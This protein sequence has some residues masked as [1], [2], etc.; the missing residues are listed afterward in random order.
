MDDQNP[1]LITRSRIDSMFYGKNTAFVK[2]VTKEVNRVENYKRR[3]GD[4][5]PISS[6]SIAMLAMQ[7]EA[8]LEKEKC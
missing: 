3:I 8:K 1:N 6:E 4:T 2:E 5:T 7:R